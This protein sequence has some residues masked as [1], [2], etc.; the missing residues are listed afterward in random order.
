MGASRTGSYDVT[1]VVPGDVQRT[2]HPA[3]I[4]ESP[5]R[6]HSVGQPKSQT[7]RGDPVRLHPHSQPSSAPAS[8]TQFLGVTWTPGNAAAHHPFGHL[9]MLSR[10]F[11]SPDGF[12]AAEPENCRPR[13][14]L[15]YGTL[16]QTPGY[17]NS[18][19]AIP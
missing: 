2:G 15:N 17:R 8:H 5:A 6:Q 16:W 11:T 9:C 14:L 12:K 18:E 19:V 1:D 13:L 7:S 3:R 10:R 4:D